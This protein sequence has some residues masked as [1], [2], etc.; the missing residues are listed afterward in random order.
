METDFLSFFTLTKAV[1]YDI[2]YMYIQKH[3]LERR[4][5]YDIYVFG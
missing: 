5:N 3:I 2:L 1:Q 4:L